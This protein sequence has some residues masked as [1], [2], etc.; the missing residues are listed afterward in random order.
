MRKIIQ[1]YLEKYLDDMA[2]S[3][4][5]TYQNRYFRYSKQTLE[6]DLCG[7][8]FSC[9]AESIEHDLNIKLTSKEYDMCEQMFNEKVVELFFI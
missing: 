8:D 5:E 4:I 2:E 9:E 7:H 6:G 1:D 3:H